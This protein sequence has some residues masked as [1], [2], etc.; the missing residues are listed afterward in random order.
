MYLTKLKRNVKNESIVVVE[1][2]ISILSETNPRII[3]PYSSFLLKINNPVIVKAVLRNID[4]TWRQR[5]RSLI[6]KIAKKPDTSDEIKQLAE[7]ALK[8]LDFSEIESI[9]QQEFLKF[10]KSDNFND[11]LLVI[12]YI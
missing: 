2:V 3:E 5:L 8:R 6:A 11:K 9:T 12:K 4:P 7:E 10:S 1:T